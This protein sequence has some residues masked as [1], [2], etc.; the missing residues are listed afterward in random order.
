MK[1]ERDRLFTAA[2]WAAVLFALVVIIP[3]LVGVGFMAAFVVLLIFNAAMFI[4][5][6]RSAPSTLGNT[7]GIAGGQY[8]KA[9]W[10]ILMVIRWKV[11]VAALFYVLLIKRRRLSGFRKWW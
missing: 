9:I 10:L 3:P 4:D 7:F 5:C 2:L 1:I 6:I 11:P 8:D